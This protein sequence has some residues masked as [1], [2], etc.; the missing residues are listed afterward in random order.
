MLNKQ[1]NKIHHHGYFPV[2]ELTTTCQ[3]SW[4][5]TCT[6]LY[7]SLFGCVTVVEVLAAAK[8]WLFT[9]KSTNISGCLS[10]TEWLATC[11]N[12]GYLLLF[13]KYLH[14]GLPV[15]ELLVMYVKT[16]VVYQYQKIKN[17]IQIKT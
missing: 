1:T 16:L 10:V 5:F 4:L 15:P 2:T 8:L 13:R 7:I 14:G 12:H 17:K 11:Q 9:S 3:K 6:N